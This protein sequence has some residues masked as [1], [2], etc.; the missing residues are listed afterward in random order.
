MKADAMKDNAETQSRPNLSNNRLS[1]MLLAVFVAIV[2]YLLIKP[3]LGPDWQRPGTAVMQSLAIAGTLLLLV[4]FM[5]SL[6]KRGGISAVPNR[7]FILHVA[8][9]I[10]GVLLVTIHASASF[11]GPPV[12]LVAALALLIVTGAVG[13]LYANRLF[14]ASFAMKPTAFTA[15]DKTN[16]AALKT[17]IDEKIQL[18]RRIDPAANEAVFSIMLVHWARHPVLSFSYERL[19]SREAQLVQNRQSLPRF[20]SWW[21]PLH[22]LLAW[23]FLAG[24][25]IHIIVVTFFAGYAADGGDIYWWHVTAW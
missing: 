25:I 17:L 24:M 5:F 19:A 11:N 20:G 23:V 4:P 9:S 7:L 18:L 1:I 13:R 6:G 15:Y 22:L 10:L 2:A 3:G 12:T 8:T 16:K 14:A 21:R